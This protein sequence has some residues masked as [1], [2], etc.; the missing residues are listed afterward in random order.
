MTLT[1]TED[2]YVQLDEDNVPI[3]VGTTMKVVELVTPVSAH[4][5]VALNHHI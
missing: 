2:K 5:E 3:I 4:I 1:N